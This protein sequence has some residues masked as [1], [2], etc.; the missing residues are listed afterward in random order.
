MTGHEI[1]KPIQSFVRREGRITPAQRRALSELLPHYVINSKPRVLNFTETFANNHP[2][3]I[4]I[5]FGNGS[6]LA[7]QAQ[8][9]PDINFIG[10]E[11]YRPG[12]GHLLQLLHK[13]GNRNV[14]ILNQDA[15]E[16]LANRIPVH[17][18]YALWLYFPDPWPK[19]KHHKRRIINQEFLDLVA[20]LL[21]PDGILHMATDWPDYAQ[22]MEREI[23]V[24]HK[25]ESINEQQP[26]G[27]PFT[28]PETHF[29]RRGLRKGHSVSEL[30]YRLK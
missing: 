15:M 10:I 14:R 27:Y 4:E 12:I 24:N 26:A 18:L 22:H 17:S 5:G 7:A 3:V 2:V 19:K 13:Q 28:R 1:K 23:L 20:G 8:Q 11:V 6:L 16:V 30:I 25:Y 21:L 9:H 29:E